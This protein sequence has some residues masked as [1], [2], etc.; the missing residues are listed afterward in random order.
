[1]MNAKGDNSKLQTIENT[2]EV[3]GTPEQ[4]WQAIA[5]GPGI[6]CWFMPA[7]IEERE[8]GTVSFDMGSGMA[9]SGTVK[10]WDPP[11]RLLYEEDW[12]GYDGASVG[13][14]ASEF[15]V[16]AR[17]GAC[18]VRLVSNLFT[19]SG[20]WDKELDDLHKG[21]NSYF[22]NLR[23]YLADFVGQRCST[24]LV[25]GHAPGSKV[26][27][28]AALLDALGLPAPVT[29]QAIASS[30]EA[31]RIAGT[32]ERIGPREVLLRLAEPAPGAAFIFAYQLGEKAV[33]NV[34]TYLYGDEAPAVATRELPRWKAW[35]ERRFPKD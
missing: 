23:L 34:H 29:G 2:I 3:T 7:E 33:V 1:M 17:S 8:G 5:T 20:D 25:T 9:P 22:E 32:V 28:Y 19:T 6:A 15:T 21:W 24:I 26:E 18:V 13:K 31:P 12:T 14:L 30:P 10:V 4:V 35:I 27:A 16:E 11:R